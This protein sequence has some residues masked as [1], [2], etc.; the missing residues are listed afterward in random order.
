MSSPFVFATCHLGAERALK[1]EVA[2]DRPDLRPAFGRPGLVTWKATAPEGVPSLLDA[3]FARVTGFALGPAGSTGEVIEHARALGAKPPLRLHAFP[4]DAKHPREGDVTDEASLAAAAELRAALL[5]AAP[6]LLVDPEALPRQG[7]PVLDVIVA[8]GEPHFVG[9]HVHGPRRSPHAGGRIPVEVPGDAPSRAFRKIEEA[10]VWSGMAVGAGQIAVEIGSAPGG[11]SLA[12]LRRG[13]A[14]TGVDPGAMAPVV[15]AH[16]RFRHLRLPVAELRLDDLPP[17]VD[18]LILDVNLAPQVA[19][20][21]A[22]AL[23]AARRRSLRGVFFT[24]K[25]ND[26]SLAERV[27]DLLRRVEAMGLAQV[28]ATQLPSNRQ[29]ICVVAAAPGRARGTGG[30]GRSRRDG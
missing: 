14:V 3:V 11:A 8:P 10:I 18:W 20:H 23:V 13:L 21:A 30:P 12:L 2:R 15:L 4:R 19:L 28:R 6:D 9:H 16:P 27:P 7:D 17:R 22:R 1:A 24:L 5:A 25:L 29:E 26:W